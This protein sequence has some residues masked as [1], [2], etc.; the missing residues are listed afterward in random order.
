MEIKCPFATRFL[1]PE[2]AIAANVSNLQ[3]LYKTEKD[4]KMKRN[5]NYYYQIQGQLHIMQRQYCIFVLWTPLGLKIEKI[6]RDDMLW[7]ENMFA[8]LVQFYENCVLSE[9]LD[10]KVERN[11]PIREPEYIIATKKQ[12]IMEKEK[13]E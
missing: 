1:M 10:P 9:L 4:E 5:H 8:K 3:S 2:D 7:A 12:K 13:T 11:M 6:L